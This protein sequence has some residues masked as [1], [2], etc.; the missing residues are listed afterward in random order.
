MTK[1]QKTFLRC[2]GDAK[3]A[4]AFVGGVSDPAV[5]DACQPL[6]IGLTAG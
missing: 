3:Q 4:L 5:Q 2:I 6:S 1:L